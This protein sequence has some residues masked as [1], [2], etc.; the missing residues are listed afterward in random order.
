MRRN[1]N[2]LDILVK[3][4]IRQRRPISRQGPTFEYSDSD[5]EAK[6]TRKQSDENASAWMFIRHHINSVRRTLTVR[7]FRVQSIDTIANCGTC[8]ATLHY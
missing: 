5:V 6:T 7:P 3:S 2:E 1:V 8:R 4:E